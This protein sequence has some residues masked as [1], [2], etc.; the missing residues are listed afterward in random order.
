[1]AYSVYFSRI[2]FSALA[3]KP[4]EKYGKSHGAV[5]SLMGHPCLSFNYNSLFFNFY[6]LV[7][8]LRQHTPMQGVIMN[9]VARPVWCSQECWLRNEKTSELQKQISDQE[10]RYQLLQRIINFYLHHLAC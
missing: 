10:E 4:V 7:D 9:I 6:Q 1:M 2:F 5:P 3:G 8:V